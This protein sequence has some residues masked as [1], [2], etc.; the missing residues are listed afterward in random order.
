MAYRSVF[1]SSVSIDS[2]VSSHPASADT[3][4]GACGILRTL[5]RCVALTRSVHRCAQDGVCKLCGFILGHCWAGGLWVKLCWPG[6]S[7]GEGGL[8]C[9]CV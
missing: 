2:C 1:D 8:A 5:C 6:F 3:S 7:C 4:A 9:V